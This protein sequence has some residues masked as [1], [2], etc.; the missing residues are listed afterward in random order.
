MENYIKYTKQLVVCLFLIY[1]GELHQ[2][3]ETI[4]CFL[5]LIYFC[6]SP[7][8]CSYMSNSECCALLEVREYSFVRSIFVTNWACLCV[9]CFSISCVLAVS[10][11]TMYGFICFRA[12]WC[13]WLNCHI[14]GAQSYS[15]WCIG[16]LEVCWSHLLLLSKTDMF[17][18]VDSRD[19]R[20]NEDIALWSIW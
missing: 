20:A 6:N 8:K 5:F 13:Y 10:S 14:W 3:Y 7:L 4:C 19:K 12:C 2:I 9:Y 16:D 18:S 17:C 11:G 15:Q 1:F